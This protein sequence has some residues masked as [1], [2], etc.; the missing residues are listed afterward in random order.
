MQIEVIERRRNID[1]KYRSVW[2][3][4]IDRKVVE[5]CEFDPTKLVQDM[6]KTLEAEGASITEQSEYRPELEK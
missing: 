4:R 2:E 5:V 1:G 3:I 6:C